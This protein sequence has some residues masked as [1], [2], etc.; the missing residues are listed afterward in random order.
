MIDYS[1]LAPFF[2]ILPVSIQII[3]P[4]IILCCWMLIKIPYELFRSEYSPTREKIA[5]EQN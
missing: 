4:L 1:I 3:L 5:L 2:W